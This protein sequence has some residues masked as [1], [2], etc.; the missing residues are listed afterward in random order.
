[1]ARNTNTAK[2]N[3]SPEATPETTVD[4]FDESVT[5]NEGTKEPERKVKYR[6]KRSLDP[7]MIVP[8]RSGFNGM[9]IYKSKHTGEKFEWSEFGEEQDMELQELKNAKASSNKAF[10]ENN[11]FIIDDPEIIEYLG[12]ERYYRNSLG[13]DEFDSLF[14]C[15]P[16]EAVAKVSSLPKG[17]KLSVVYRARKLID[18]GVLDSIKMINALEKCLNVEL[19]D[20]AG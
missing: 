14:K 6:A 11:W 19:I 13:I 3:V 16:E 10:F 18:D 15:T 7:H 4:S 12:V 8:V 5:A 2:A 1:M 9:L 20:R 17:Q